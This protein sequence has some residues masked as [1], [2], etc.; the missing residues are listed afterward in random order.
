MGVVEGRQAAAYDGGVVPAG[1][2]ET[3][4]GNMPLLGLGRVSGVVP[5]GQRGETA[6]ERL[7][8]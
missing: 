4:Y 1:S 3:I 5:V 7:G 8:S 6:A 2:T